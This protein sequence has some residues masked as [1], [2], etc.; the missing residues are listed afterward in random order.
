ML[1]SPG[2]GWPDPF[3]EI[4]SLKI[5]SLAYLWCKTCTHSRQLGH[6]QSGKHPGSLEAG[7]R[8]A[9]PC[10]WSLNKTIFLISQ[11]ESMINPIILCFTYIISCGS[12]CK[13]CL[14]RFL[15]SFYRCKD[16]SSNMLTNLIKTTELEN[17]G[18]NILTQTLR[19]QKKKKG[20]KGCIPSWVC[21]TWEKTKILNLRLYF[22][23]FD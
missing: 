2:L 16:W 4:N 10:L 20:M 22:W 9:L 12:L 23:I 18:A 11:T 14:G 13:P 21:E 5:P 6:S 8:P 19:S 3:Q 17:G 7:Q 1:I 15:S